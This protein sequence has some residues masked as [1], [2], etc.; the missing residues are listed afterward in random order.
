MEFV[1]KRQ[2][3]QG[4]LSQNRHFQRHVY[5]D[6]AISRNRYTHRYTYISIFIFTEY[7]AASA[8]VLVSFRTTPGTCNKTILTLHLIHA[9]KVNLPERVIRKKTI[10]IQLSVKPV[11]ARTSE[12]KHINRSFLS[13]SLLVQSFSVLFQPN[14]C[15]QYELT[16]QILFFIKLISFWEVLI[17]IQA[18]KMEVN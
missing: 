16:H 9:P 14:Q 15:V 6:R 1:R 3:K 10:L 7:L 17:D 8:E 4:Q 5:A 13:I 2:R 11:T 18:K 12:V